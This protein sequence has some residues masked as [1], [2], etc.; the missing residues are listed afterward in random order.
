MQKWL[1]PTW[2]IVARRGNT[3]NYTAKHI[4]S[5]IFFWLFSSNWNTTGAFGNSLL[6][7]M[8]IINITEFKRNIREFQ[9]EQLPKTEDLER[10]MKTSWDFICGPRASIWTEWTK[11]STLENKKAFG[12]NLAPRAFP[13]LMSGAPPI[14]WGKRPVGRGWFGGWDI[15]CRIYAINRP[16]RVI[17]GPW[18]WALYETGVY[19]RLGFY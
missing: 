7:T 18:E 5:T 16:G 2:T 13:S 8:I 15:I 1:Q 14:F 4:F 17:F 10:N 6:N 12:S 3:E 11:N 19:S 9:G